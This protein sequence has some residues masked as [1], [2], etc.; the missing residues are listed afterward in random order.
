MQAEAVQQEHNLV[1][2]TVTLEAVGVM[3][4]QGDTDRDL[5]IHPTLPSSDHSQYAP[6]PLPRA[7]LCVQGMDRTCA[8]DCRELANNRAKLGRPTNKQSRGHPRGHACASLKHAAAAQKRCLT[9]LT[10][11]S[12]L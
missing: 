7:R 6:P 2:V 10:S 12:F 8:C 4:W 3:E 5:Y 9:F 1:P 11:V